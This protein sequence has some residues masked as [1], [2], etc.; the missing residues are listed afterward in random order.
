MAFL[1]MV[2]FVGAQCRWPCEGWAVG[3]W[4]SCASRGPSMFVSSCNF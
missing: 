1:S 3:C 4:R 2:E